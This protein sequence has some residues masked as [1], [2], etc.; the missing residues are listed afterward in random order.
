M[1]E[2]DNQCSQG[3][4]TN[5]DERVHSETCFSCLL[6]ECPT[7]GSLISLTGAPAFLNL[8][9]SELTKMLSLPI[10][11]PLETEWERILSLRELLES[12]YV[13]T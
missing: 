12:K 6:R 9:T 7:P 13:F 2:V 3:C 8:S 11:H 5:I 10:L 1:T 4:V